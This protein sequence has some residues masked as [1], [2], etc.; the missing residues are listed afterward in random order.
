[1]NGSPPARTGYV[2][3]AEGGQYFETGDGKP[4]RILGENVCWPGSRGTYDYELWFPAMQAAGENYARLWMCPWAFGIETDPDSLVRYRQDRAFQLDYV[5]GLAEQTGVYLLLCLDY[6]GMWEVT[7]DYWGGN[8]YW[9]ANPY[10]SA[11]GGPCI[12][13][14]AFFT[15]ATARTTYQKRLR[16]LVAR[17]GYSPNL[18]G[19]QFF[20]EIDNVYSY[21]K[22]ADVASWHGVMGAWLKAN[23]S[24]S[25][26]VTTSLTGNSERPE[27]WQ[28]P[29]LDFATY[30]SYGEPQPANRLSAVAQSFLQRY[31][32]PMIIDEFGSDW[33]GWNREND[34]F[35]R[36][37]RQGLWGGALGGSAGASVSWWWENIHNENLY[38]IYSA[39]DRI[40]GRT[41]WGS[42]TWTN[43]GFRTAGPPP[44]SAGESLTNAEP[45][46]VLLVPNAAWG[47]KPGGQLAVVDPDSAVYSSSTLNSFVH[48]TGHPELRVPFRLSAWLAESARIVAHLNSVSDGAIMIVKVDGTERF[49]TNLPNL[50]GSWNVNGEYNMDIPVNISSGKH[51]VEIANAG[52]DWFFLDWVRM[53]R[54]QP[55]TYPNGWQPS[56]D[57]IGLRGVRESLF[58]VVAPGL[59]FPGHATNSALKLQIDQTITLTNWPE[60]TFFAEWYDPAT[61]TPAGTGSAVS[62]NGA[63]SFPLPAFKEDLT[64]ILYPK[65]LL[66]LSNGPPSGHVSLHLQ[67]ETGGRY[68]IET[69][70]DLT[71]WDTLMTVT[72][73]SGLTE[74]PLP[75]VDSNVFFR[76]AKPF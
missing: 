62:S 53:E 5:F 69:T 63:L 57:A 51:L 3:L 28:V 31:R 37:F 27:I 43:I 50:D 18:L 56:A 25:H 24:Y 35:L 10:N 67:S 30:H 65:P 2:K 76:A 73:V 58:Y 33:R 60:G 6:H 75:V 7:P 42:G 47:G 26:L 44:T 13:Q 29:Q 16:Y 40:L 8:N 15:N 59:S 39:M 20:N 49:R 38:G 11:N 34:P 68:A 45:F 64:G 17:Y 74:I 54:V 4:L 19:W 1:V 12:N 41:G 70:V 22:P 46:D 14:N 23:D 72:N 48:G 71:R 55:S 21:L 52:G 36:G 66:N 9:P 61:G 32:K